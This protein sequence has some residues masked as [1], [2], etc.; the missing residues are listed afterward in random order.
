MR[1]IST[2]PDKRLPYFALLY[3]TLLYLRKGCPAY[4]ASRTARSQ[5]LYFTLLY[6]TLL[7]FT[8]L[9]FTLLYFTLLTFVRG[10]LHVNQA[11]KRLLF[12]VLF[13]EDR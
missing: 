5:L 13:P 9:Y 8:L 10:A 12:A 2:K 1:C 3:F 11:E 6:F 4:Q 7:Y